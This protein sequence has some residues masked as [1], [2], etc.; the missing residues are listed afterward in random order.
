MTRKQL[1]KIIAFVLTVTVIT[2]CLNKI[3]IAHG[4]DTNY[5]LMTG[6]YQEEEDSLDAVY[7]GGSN[8]YA[9][10][11]APVAWEEYGIKV[12]PFACNMLPF[13]AVP[14]MIEEARKTQPDALYI[15]SIN[16]LWDEISAEQ[17][18]FATDYMKP[19]ATKLKMLNT[20]VDYANDTRDEENK[21]GIGEFIFPFSVYHNRW[22]EF[23]FKDLFKSVNGLKGANTFDEYF[24]LQTDV[25]EY[26][27]D[28]NS[29]GSVNLSVGQYETVQ[30]II[31][32]CTEENVNVLF[33]QS[34][35]AIAN[36]DTLRRFN[37]IAQL[38][39][40][41]GFPFLNFT[42]YISEMG[43]D[44]TC[45][46]YN[47][48]HVNIHGALKLTRFFSEYLLENYN[49]GDPEPSQDWDQ[50]YDSYIEI[51]RPYVSEDELEG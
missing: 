21:I 19:S 33:I 51:I 1:T 4:S 12:Y 42:D 9:F 13:E 25:S 2:A 26:F 17:I 31:D 27:A 49:F 22:S 41:A 39:Q 20:L 18:H 11:L 16:G 48:N 34:P 3:F 43:I 46:Y 29:V 45:D 7:I 47:V 15:I 44:T 23:S 50:S 36:E 24:T 32:Y 10:W 6:F 38:V 35:Q 5:Q 37:T 28:Q 8:V 30:R 40:D 14:F